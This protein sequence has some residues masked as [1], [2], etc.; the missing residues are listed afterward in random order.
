MVSNHRRF[1]GSI[2]YPGRRGGQLTGVGPLARL[3]ITRDLVAFDFFFPI[4]VFFRPPSITRPNLLEVA[5]TDFPTGR[6]NGVKFTAQGGA[7]TY[8]YAVE[9]ALVVRELASNGYEVLA[10]SRFF[11][12]LA[13]REEW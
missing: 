6:V 11:D 9:H 8:F 13:N 10:H 1:W 7:T 4:S 5:L 3:Q 2:T 12:A